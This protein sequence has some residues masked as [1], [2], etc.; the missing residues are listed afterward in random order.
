MLRL[1]KKYGNNQVY[2]AIRTILRMIYTITETNIETIFRLL[3]LISKYIGVALGII[4]CYCVYHII[5]MIFLNYVRD[6]DQKC[7]DLIFLGWKFCTDLFFLPL[8][9]FI[10]HGV[11]AEVML[12]L[13]FEIFKTKTTILRGVLYSVIF[14]L[15]STLIVGYLITDVPTHQEFYILIRG[16]RILSFFVIYAP[17]MVT[18][19]IFGGGVCVG[20]F[21][22]SIAMVIW[23]IWI[24]TIEG[25]KCLTGGWNWIKNYV[26]NFHD[27]IQE[28][29]FVI[30]QKE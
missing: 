28:E 8:F 7:S 10:F 25:W 17:I 5:M 14:C 1:H 21:V 4:I 13:V 23:V 26:G 24:G 27:E 11:A 22:I 6:P 12:L 3:F 30:I 2:V 16:K 15:I 20:L 9:I 18:F 19:G 29:I